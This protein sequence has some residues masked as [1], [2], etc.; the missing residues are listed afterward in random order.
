MMFSPGASL[1]G[2]IQKEK[3]KLS[4]CNALPGANRRV[5]TPG[6][7]CHRIWRPVPSTPLTV[8]GGVVELS[9]LIL[10]PLPLQSA[11]EGPDSFNF[12][13]ATKLPDTMFTGGATI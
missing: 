9:R 10:F 13:W 1:T 2:L 11:Y 7:C 4:V 12:Q 3:P 8:R 5:E 6:F